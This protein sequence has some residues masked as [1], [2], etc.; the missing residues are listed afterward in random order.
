MKIYDGCLSDCFRMIVAGA[1]A[2]GKSCFVEELLKNQYGILNQSFDRAIYL[3]GVKTSTSQNLREIFDDKL[4]CFDGIPREDVLLPLCRDGQGKLIL[5]IDDLDQEALNSPL[6]SKI[7][8]VYSHHLN[9][10][11]CLTTQNFFRPGKERLTLVRNATHLV[12]FPNPMDG[13][14][15]RIISQKVFATKPKALV[16]L[17]EKITTQP[18]HYL[19]I[20]SQCDPELRFRSGIL[21]PYQKVYIA[22]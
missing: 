9:F 7:F 8:T 10:S 3:R 4:I 11:V 20:W 17:F 2:V 6:I 21:G 14:I 19:T 5:L 12:L 13:S 15:I 16:E 18:F 22:E 1:S